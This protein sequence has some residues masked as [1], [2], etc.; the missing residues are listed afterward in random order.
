MTQETFALRCYVTVGAIN[1][2]DE[3]RRDEFKNYVVF[4]FINVLEMISVEVCVT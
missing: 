1:Y 2:F 3:E 4:V